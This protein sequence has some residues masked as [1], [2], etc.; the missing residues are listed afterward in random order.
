MTKKKSNVTEA[1]EEQMAA[2]AKYKKIEVSAEEAQEAVDIVY[3]I[4]HG[5]YYSR[6]GPTLDADMAARIVDW[7]KVFMA[8]KVK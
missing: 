3:K 1:I 8:G 5:L 4:A 7:L 6:S 2:V